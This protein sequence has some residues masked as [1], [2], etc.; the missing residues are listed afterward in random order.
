MKNKS[1]QKLKNL[2]EFKGK[3]VLITGSGRGIGAEL[4]LN[5]GLAGAKVIINYLHSKKKALKLVKKLKNIDVEVCPIKA[6]VSKRKQVEKMINLTVSKYNT[7]D[8]LINNAA[9]LPKPMGW[10]KISPKDWERTMQVNTQGMFECCRAVAPIMLKKKGSKIVNISTLGG[11][12]FIAAYIASKTAINHLTKAFAQELAPNINV[13]AVA[14]SKIE[15]GMGKPDNK[16]VADSYISETPMK[17]LGKI[18]DVVNA[19]F[20]LA[21]KNSD[22]ITGQILVV[23][24]GRSIRAL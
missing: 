15:V 19:V 13:N 22:F 3:V 24:G 21:S 5:F 11:G 16:Q 12:T 2:S 10:K 18:S 8:I 4:A 14:L 6:D 9:V 17:R 20:Y 7:I 23:D 1:K